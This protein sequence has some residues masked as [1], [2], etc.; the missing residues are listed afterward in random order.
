MLKVLKLLKYLNGSKNLIC[1]FLS[2]LLT[3][4]SRNIS[5]LM[6]CSAVLLWGCSSAVPVATHPVG[7]ISTPPVNQAEISKN[8]KD[9]DNGGRVRVSEL[10]YIDEVLTARADH[11]YSNRHG[12]F[13]FGKNAL[14]KFNCKKGVTLTSVNSMVVSVSSILENKDHVSTG[15]GKNNGYIRYVRFVK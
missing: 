9:F 10:T 15:C 13:V 12:K 5:S 11:S 8:S 1:K 4:W 6:M 3:T 2:G 7:V 14:L